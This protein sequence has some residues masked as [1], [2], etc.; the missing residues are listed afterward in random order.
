[1]Q[2]DIW[3]RLK[4][5]KFLMAVANAGFIF[6]NEVLQHPVDPQFYWQITLAVIAFI[7]GESVVDAA[8]KE[9]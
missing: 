2:R 1:M 8:K 7:P 5:R 4:S 9:S 6:I 3:T